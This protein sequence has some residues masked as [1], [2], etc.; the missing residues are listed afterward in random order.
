MHAVDDDEDDKMLLRVVGGWSTVESKV[1]L[2]I[3]KKVDLHVYEWK[4]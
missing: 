4:P 1:S 2:I 3:Q